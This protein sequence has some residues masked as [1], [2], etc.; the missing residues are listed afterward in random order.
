[1]KSSENG[2]SSILMFYK[3]LHVCFGLDFGAFDFNNAVVKRSVNYCSLLATIAIC[4]CVI[5]FSYICMSFDVPGSLYNMYNAVRHIIIVFI[6]LG[7]NINLYKFVLVMRNIDA[8]LKVREYSEIK[9]VIILLLV[10]SYRAI[11]SASFY[12]AFQH[13]TL[14][15]VWFPFV[16]FFSWISHDIVLITNSL[17]YHYASRPLESLMD[18]LRSGQA[19]YVSFNNVFKSIVEVVESVKSSFDLVVSS[20]T[21][22]IFRIA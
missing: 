5:V 20:A 12:L 3:I 10:V 13:E 7:S 17:I 16:H 8:T 6:L 2:P 4:V 19:R 21:L 9:F 18:V 22:Y 15:T 1:M 14:V 11:T